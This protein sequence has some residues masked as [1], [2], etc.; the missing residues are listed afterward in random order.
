MG[1]AHIHSNPIYAF[2]LNSRGNGISPGLWGA[3][4]MAIA[5]HEFIA[6][7]VVPDLI[8]KPLEF[9]ILTKTAYL[10][11]ASEKRIHR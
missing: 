11:A 2:R 8:A 10:C 5:P 9:S 6:A 7:I 1:V 4:A 3:S